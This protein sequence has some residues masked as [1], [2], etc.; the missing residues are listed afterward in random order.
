MWW[1]LLPVIVVIR[2]LLSQI[3]TGVLQN[4]NHTLQTQLYCHIAVLSIAEARGLQ[5]TAPI[6]GRRP[7][8]GGVGGF[9]SPGFKTDLWLGHL[10][11]WKHHE[12]LDRYNIYLFSIPD[13]VQHLLLKGAASAF[14]TCNFIS[15]FLLPILA[16]RWKMQLIS[17]LTKMVPS[18]KRSSEKGR[19][20]M[21]LALEIK[22]LFTTLEHSRMEQNLTQAGIAMINLNLI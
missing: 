5:Q 15:F 19:A 12:G 1:I 3:M 8:G 10:T 4:V 22:S 16:A 9:L 13:K 7:G 18:W 14:V 21:V 17:V 6:Q 2:G 11:C 20:T